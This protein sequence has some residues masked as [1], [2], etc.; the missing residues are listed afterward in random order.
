MS[1]EK[2][3]WYEQGY[4]A[5][6]RE[7]NRLDSMNGPNRFWMPQ[8]QNKE[9]VFVDD[10]PFAIYEHNPKMNG[11]FKNWITCLKESNADASCCQVLGDNT[12]YFV[13]YYTVVDCSKFVSNKGNTY[14]FEVKFL[15]AKMKTLK[16]LRRKKEDR[17]S[18][19]GSMF[20]A[21]RDDEKSPGV[22]DEYEY[23]RDVDM[24][25]L[26]GLANYG[27]KKLTELWQK[28]TEN[29]ESLARLKRIFQ[30]TMGADGKP[31]PGL[32][33][34]NYLTLLEPKSPKEVRDLLR[35]FVKEEDEKSGQKSDADDSTEAGADEQVPF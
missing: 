31:M 11:S 6:S 10:E 5:M 32:A 14:Q 27:G 25:K 34:F 15:P 22:G 17:G 9:L 7:Q 28:S 21:Y 30:I 3:S 8:G 26:F 12:R 16:K 4:S 13:G 29:A 35:G 24:T 33:P 1:D 2:R 20:R 19:V 18:L 23:V